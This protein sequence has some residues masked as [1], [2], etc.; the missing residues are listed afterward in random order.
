MSICLSE[1][2][3]D[4]SLVLFGEEETDICVGKRQ[5]LAKGS[6]QSH[7]LERPQH[8]STQSMWGTRKG[9]LTDKHHFYKEGPSRHQED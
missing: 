6:N 2:R 3:E 7:L 4:R 5:T 9:L 1:R 8:T